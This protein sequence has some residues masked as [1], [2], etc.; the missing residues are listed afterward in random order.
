MDAWN[1]E[2]LYAEIWKRPLIKVAANYSISAVM[3]GKVCRKLQIPLPGRG[4]WAKK[5]FGKPVDKIPLP[6]VENL[7]VVHRLKEMGSENAQAPIPEPEPTDPEYQ[8]IL[9]VES[10]AVIAAPQAT[11]HKLVIAGAKSL[12]NAKPDNRG[13]VQPSWNESALDIRVSKNSID[14]ALNIMNAI[15]MLLESEK[16][17]VAV[18]SGRHG[19]TAYVFGHNVPFSIVEKAREKGRKEVPGYSYTHTEI[20]YQP[21][22]ELE[23]RAADQ[24]YGD[25]KVRDGKT[26]KLESLISKCAGAIL[27]EA[28]DRVIWA[29][30]RRLEEIEERK[31]A[32]QRAALAEQIAE[33]EK[34]VKD[35]DSWV[36]SWERA[37]KMRDF[38]S[39]LQKMWKKEG[40]DISPESE[41][42]QRIFWMKQQ[43]DRLDPLV[44]SP[45]SILDRNPGLNRW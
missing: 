16:V 41:K 5:E 4:Y 22:G 45:K 20:E 29:E 21:S 25:K 23:F 24:F 36:N 39:A 43:A 34:K 11:W 27:R 33:E 3:L 7:P 38:I 44:E 10:R 18:K 28:R 13:I 9:Q 17:A 32:Q 14:R 37:Q 15:I 26:Q 6:K 12:R 2:E 8:R 40:H 42:G 30:K 19:T 35:L 1:R 31:N